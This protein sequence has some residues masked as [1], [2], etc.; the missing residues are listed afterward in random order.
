MFFPSITQVVQMW[1]TVLKE[2]LA[3][4][5]MRTVEVMHRLWSVDVA[6]RHN[7]EVVSSDLDSQPAYIA[8]PSH[9]QQPHTGKN[10]G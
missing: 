9:H 1:N 2:G 6:R 4:R 5:K 10:G 8:R 7:R 3:V